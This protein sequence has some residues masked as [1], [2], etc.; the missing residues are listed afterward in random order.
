MKCYWIRDTKYVASRVNCI[1][2][3]LLGSRKCI[4]ITQK[5][6]DHL[7]KKSGQ[8]IILKFCTKNVRIYET[9]EVLLDQ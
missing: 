9:S 5:P 3:S 6:H 7:Y 2:S 8:L 4:C 1:N